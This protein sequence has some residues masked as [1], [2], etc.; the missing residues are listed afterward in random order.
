MKGMEIAAAGDPLPDN[1]LPHALSD[2]DHDAAKR[3]SERREGIETV[4]DLLVRRG[5]TLLRHGLQHL[6]DLVGPGARFPEQRELALADLHRLGTYGDEREFGADQDASRLGGWGRH[7]EEQ[8][9]S[10]L[11]VLGDLL[12]NIRQ[13]QLGVVRLSRKT[14]H[15]CGH[16][17]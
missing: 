12:H 9:I 3:I 5:G 15:R 13:Y 7:V 17:L 11:I 8:E 2:L 14:N 10:G 16:R 1:E 4:H 6:L